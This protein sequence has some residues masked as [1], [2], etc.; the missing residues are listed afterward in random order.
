MLCLPHARVTVTD[1]KDHN[2][3]QSVCATSLWMA[4]QARP[5]KISSS[6]CTNQI[7][8]H[9]PGRLQEIQACE[10]LPRS[11]KICSQPVG[12]RQGRDKSVNRRSAG[13]QAEGRARLV[14]PSRL[15][16]QTR[17]G[18]SELEIRMVGPI[19]TS[20]VELVIPHNTCP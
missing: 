13:R 10:S 15:V 14:V 2:H 1:D 18:R 3:H 7:V 12:R 11:C 6:L 16:T 17:C 5:N 19:S 20:P 4:C 8:L 9:L